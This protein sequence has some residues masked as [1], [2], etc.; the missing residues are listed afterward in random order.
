MG[1]EA[2]AGG[3]M[4]IANSKFG[5]Q[6]P[7]SKAKLLIVQVREAAKTEHS[8]GA[9]RTATVADDVKSLALLGGGIKGTRAMPTKQQ[10]S[11]VTALSR[12]LCPPAEQNGH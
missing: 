8:Q 11:Q 4:G 2:L 12:G 10:N 5:R 1:E 3:R 9:P 6:K 7:L